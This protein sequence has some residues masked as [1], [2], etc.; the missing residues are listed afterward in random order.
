MSLFCSC[1][2]VFYP[3]EYMD[4]W[5][6]LSETSIPEKYFC[7]H[8]NMEDISDTDYTHLKRLCKNFEIK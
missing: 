2:D 3:C 5:G 8:L 4:D 1:K 6:K 7:C